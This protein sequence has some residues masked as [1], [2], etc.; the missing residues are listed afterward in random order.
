MEDRFGDSISGDNTPS[1]LTTNSCISSLKTIIKKMIEKV[2]SQS[3]VFRP[4]P[5]GDHF[6]SIGFDAGLSGFIVQMYQAICIIAITMNKMMTK[7]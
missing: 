5:F 3:T 1:S 2:F 6:A 7:E 4:R